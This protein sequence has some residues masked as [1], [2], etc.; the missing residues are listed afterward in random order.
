MD[1]AISLSSGI[2]MSGRQTR[3]SEEG[4]AKERRAKDEGAKEGGAKAG[5]GVA[6]EE[7][8]GGDGK[9]TY[10]F[11]VFCSFGCKYVQCLR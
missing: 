5:D 2:K 11:I 1:G 9:Y 8:A 7:A 10:C 4:G 6:K 3:Q